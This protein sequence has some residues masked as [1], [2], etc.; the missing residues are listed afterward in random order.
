MFYVFFGGH[1][2]IDGRAIGA[3]VIFFLSWRMAWIVVFRM[4]LGY[5]REIIL[6][7]KLYI[8]V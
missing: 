1:V 2:E 7:S 8:A 5:A 4:G 6:T 3:S